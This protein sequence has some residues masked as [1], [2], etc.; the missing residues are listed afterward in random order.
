MT[1]RVRVLAVL[2]ADQGKGPDQLAA[3]LTFHEL[4]K[5]IYE[6][7]YEVNNRPDWVEIPLRGLAVI[8]G[9]EFES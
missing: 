1:D 3:L 2:Q 8:A 6:I 5:V 4:E 9:L 7:G